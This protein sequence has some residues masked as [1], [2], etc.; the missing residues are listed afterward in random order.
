VTAR[1]TPTVGRVV[2]FRPARDLLNAARFLTYRIE[3][4]GRPLFSAQVAFVHDDGRINVGFMDHAGNPG[5][6]GPV[7]IWQEGDAPHAP[8]VA[9]CEWM[10]YQKGQAAKTE[11]LEKALDTSTVEGHRARHAQLHR[12]LDE[13]LA[14]W[15]RCSP[16]RVQF[17][18][19]PLAEL[20]AWSH[21]QTIKPDEPPR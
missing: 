8:D 14:D 10:P 4:D 3:P 11:Q 9:Y 21:R 6:Y 13:L 18:N 20:L 7:S 2:W 15:M 17:I 5:Q 1:I 16:D 12:G 19:A